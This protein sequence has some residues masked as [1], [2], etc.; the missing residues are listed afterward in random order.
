MLTIITSNI[1]E[2]GRAEGVL[3]DTVPQSRPLAN[4]ISLSASD[5]R[6]S[7]EIQPGTTA[8]ETASTHRPT[9]FSGTTTRP[10]TPYADFAK[11]NE[12]WPD[13]ADYELIDDVE[14]LAHNL[15]GSGLAPHCHPRVEALYRRAASGSGYYSQLIRASGLI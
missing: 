9:V 1:S 12:D 10:T 14:E 8:V 2:L 7:A 6:A 4:P 11:S 5:R 15:L 13:E 3:H